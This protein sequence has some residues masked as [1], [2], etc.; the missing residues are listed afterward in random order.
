MGNR[1]GIASVTAGL[2]LTTYALPSYASDTPVEVILATS[3]EQA[4]PENL[5]TLEVAAPAEPRASIH[6][7]GFSV[8]LPP[9]PPPVKKAPPAKKTAAA[10]QGS[11]AS[12]S[13]SGGIT[14][15]VGSGARIS[16]GFGYRAAP[17]SGCSTNH[18]G[19]DFTPGNGTP[20]KAMAA[21]VVS[22]AGSQGSYGTYVMV[23]HVIAGQ[24]ITTVYAHLQSNSLGVSA[25][26]NI[27]QGQQ[28]GRV[29]ST[30]AS[31]GPHLHF[32]VRVN[33]VPVNP[34]PWMKANG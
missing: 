3:V 4:E 19:V 17:C 30:G 34:V 16:S 24:K 11:A 22:Y 29:G 10:S 23:D 15:P 9:P 6:R 5:Q 27:A 26:Q 18:K 25:G 13:S 20:V 8:T 32:E 28:V 33:G 2:L 14:W 1:L 12:A 21:G 7:D 31:T